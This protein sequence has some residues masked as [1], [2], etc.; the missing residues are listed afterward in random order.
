MVASIKMNY[1]KLKTL[2]LKRFNIPKARS[3]NRAI[4]SFTLAEK[5]VFYFFVATF[6]LSGFVLLFRVNASFLTEIPS[7]GGSLAE[8]VVGNPRFINPVLAIS[9]ADKSLSALVYS[10][11]LR[12]LP[13]GSIQND[14]AESLFISE[15]GLEYTLK[16]REDAVFHDGTPVTA[17]DV[18]FTVQKIAD[19]LIKSPQRGNWD[20]VTVEKLDELTVT[21][22]LKKAYSPFVENLTIGILPKH[23]WKNVTGDEFS[24]SQFNTL[25]IGSGPYVINK[26]E[27]NPGGIPDYYSLTPFTEDG[28]REPY[29]KK[30]VF[31]FYP[32]EEALISAY[33]KG[34]IESIGG[35]SAERAQ[36]LKEGGANVLTY[37]LPRVFGVLFQPEQL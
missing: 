4:N 1:H 15:D 37:P 2:L 33:Q 22:H 6:V 27:R 14:L 10:G 34:D 35:V 28:S 7:S 13:D 31:K 24:F 18:V 32:S 26:V 8:G 11:L 16:V 21:F 23:I 17:D 25:P 30:L 36:K 12:A 5:T 3:I 9:E 19:P 20:G 29:I